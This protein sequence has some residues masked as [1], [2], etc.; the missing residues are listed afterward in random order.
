MA[1]RSPNKG[2][3]CLSGGLDSAAV[4][5]IYKADINSC[6]FINYGSKQ[7]ARE[8]KASRA[9]AEYYKKPWRELDMSQA[10]NSFNSALLLGNPADIQKG[11]YSD[12]EVSNAKVPFRNGIFIA[13]LT[14]LAESLNLSRVYIGV[15][16][17]D[18]RLYPDCTPEFIYSMNRTIHTYTS[19]GEGDIIE[20]VAPFVGFQKA[21]IAQHALESKL[22]INLTYSCYVGGEIHCGECPTCIERRTS[23][24]LSDTTEYLK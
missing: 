7:N 6:I 23:L 9:L 17:G 14:G 24:G 11:P 1:N 3:L 4:L 13:M 2:L 15:H 19:H 8:R 10:F 20:V 21:E 12:I 18:H 5:A 16:A 22:P